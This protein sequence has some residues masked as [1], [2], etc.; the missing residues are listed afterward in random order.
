MRQQHFFVYYALLAVVQILLCN[1]FTFTP[2]VTLTILPVMVLCIPTKYST[3][4]AMVIAFAT[5]GLVDLL[6]DGVVGLNTFA[7]VPVALARRGV[8]RFVFGA[9][10][11]AR[12]DDFSI[13]K[14]GIG[15]VL[16]AIALVQ[17]LFL[18]LYLWAD[19]GPSRTFGFNV[20]RLACSLTC[21]ALL[22]VFVAD[23]LTPDDRR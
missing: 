5:G 10:L 15:K 21:G 2:Y 8:C 7:L 14:Y 3:P 19:G 13:R 4:L 22:S 11:I 6:A 1:Y 20:L 16:F 23:I 9:E 12:E 18:V 17:T